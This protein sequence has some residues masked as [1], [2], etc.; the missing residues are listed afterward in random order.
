MK[1][2]Y[3]YIGGSIWEFH[4]RIEL[5]YVIVVFSHPSEIDFSVVEELI[6]IKNMVSMVF[7]QTT[8]P[9]SS[10]QYW[11]IYYLDF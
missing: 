6:S 3:L 11:G 10:P 7:Y 1:A 8:S 4:T 5:H 2:V 9:Y